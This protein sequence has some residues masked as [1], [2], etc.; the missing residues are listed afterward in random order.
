VDIG[1]SSVA[2]QELFE[3][4]TNI[5]GTRGHISRPKVRSRYTD[6]HAK[7]NLFGK[8]DPLRANFQKCFPKV[9]Y[10]SDDQIHVLCVNF[11]KFGRLEIGKVVRCLLDKKF[12]SL[13]RSRF[14]AN[15]AQNL[16]E[17]A[18]DNILGQPQFSSK[19]VHFRL[20]YSRTRE[21]R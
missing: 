7:V 10:L 1:P 5:K 6:V 21:H 8:K 3:I 19:S 4:D 16:P 2:L 13:S 12:R 11:M 18:P 14:C 20:C 15:R 9:Y 17:P